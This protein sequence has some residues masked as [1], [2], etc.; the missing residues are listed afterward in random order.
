[1]NMFHYES[2][3]ATSIFL[4]WIFISIIAVLKKMNPTKNFYIRNVE[5]I[6]Q[7]GLITLTGI[8]IEK[9]ENLIHENISLL[10]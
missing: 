4:Y 3:L 5:T 9:N 10:Y 8:I 2:V 6:H 1:M 7:G